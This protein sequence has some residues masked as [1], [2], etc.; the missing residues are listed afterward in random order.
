MDTVLKVIVW[1]GACYLIW[2]HLLS[3]K[4]LIEARI[5]CVDSRDHVWFEFLN[6]LQGIVSFT[7][8]ATLFWMPAIVSNVISKRR[9][10]NKTSRKFTMTWVQSFQ[11]ALELY[12]QLQAWR[13]ND[14][15]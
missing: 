6:S 3:W 12:Q 13:R 7:I 15:E 14:I 8:L 5:K 4:W 9:K 2:G 10:R 11:K 1:M